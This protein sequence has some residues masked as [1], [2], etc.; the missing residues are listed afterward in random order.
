MRIADLIKPLASDAVA[1]ATT[2]KPGVWIYQASVDCQCW[3][4]PPL[5]TPIACLTTR[6]TRACPPNI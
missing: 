6:G 2:T 4:A 1:G 3:A 5:R